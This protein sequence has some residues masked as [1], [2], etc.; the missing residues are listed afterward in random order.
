MRPLTLRELAEASIIDPKSSPLIEKDKRYFS[1]TDILGFLS[2]LVSVVYGNN[3]DSYTNLNKENDSATIGE[4]DE[5]HSTI[6]LAHFSVKEYLVS[7]RI[8][9]S[10]CS[11]YS[12]KEIPA[13]LSIAETCLAYLLQFDK[14][15]SLTSR[16]LELPLLGYAAEYWTQHARWAGED[17][18]EIHVLTMEFFSSKRHAYI[19]WV[20]LFDPDQPWMKPEITKGFKRLA[21]PLYYTALTGLVI[22]LSQLLQKGA[23]VNAQGGLYRTALQAASAKGHDQ[24]VQR[25]LEDGADVK[26]ADQDGWTPLHRASWYGHVDVV[27]RL[28]EDGAD[29]KSAAQDGSTPLHLASE[30][31]HVDVVQRLLEGGADVKAAAQDRSTP[32]DWASKGGYADVVK[33]LDAAQGGA[34]IAATDRHVNIVK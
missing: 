21:S 19:N 26:A 2:G 11:I 1:P 24:I 8:Q 16:T 27:Q 4:V 7:D 12:I 31:G 30:C 14:P 33:L 10:R 5:K 3:S 23:N 20:R 13:N 18:I 25:L 32:V 6:I 22:S 9:A 17:A 15:D 28:L 29:V 34:D